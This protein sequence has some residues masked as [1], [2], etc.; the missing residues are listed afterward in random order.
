MGKL[1]HYSAICNAGKLIPVPFLLVLNCSLQK[2]KPNEVVVNQTGNKV[3]HNCR[4]LAKSHIPLPCVL[5]ASLVIT[6]RPTLQLPVRR[7]PAALHVF[8]RAF[9]AHMQSRLSV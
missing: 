3:Q 6:V 2:R 1:C 7:P 4:A 8:W 9:L 5:L